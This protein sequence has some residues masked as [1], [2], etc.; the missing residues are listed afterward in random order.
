MISLQRYRDLF[1]LPE[2][3]PV[4]TASIVA[5]MPIGIAGLAILLFVQTR[6]SSFAVAGLV[7]GFYVLGLAA[8]AP[9]LGRLIDR[10]GPRRV[11]SVCAML[12][13][14]ALMVLT[15]LV[16]ARVHPTWLAVMALI[17]G[18]SLPPVSACVRALY[19]RV[20]SEP[21]LLQ[22]VYSVDSAAVEL[23]FT[24][25]PALV[26]ACVAV[27]HP[28]AAVG[29]AALFA[30]VGTGVF[31]RVPTVRRWE[32]SPS[33]RKR[34][35]LGALRQP[36]LLAVFGATVLY[37]IAFGLYEVGVTAHTASKG[38]PA[39][40]GIA[41]ALT[42]VGSG[43]GAIVY[44]ATHWETPLARQFTLALSAMAC[45]ILLLVPIDGL[46][47]YAAVAT[48]TGIPMSSVIAT[49]SQLVSRIASRERLAE[50]FTWAATCLLVGV[51]AG[52]AI[53]GAMAEVLPAYWLIAAA[54]ASTALA[55][56][57]SAVALRSN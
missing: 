48:L 3:R 56:L 22:T 53:G 32:L 50:S 4:V 54:A 20:V 57:W 8:I 43:A 23:V 44:G 34:S 2:V 38:S 28:E 42:S 31:V 13:P 55:A 45:G 29:L 12:Y 17:A 6:S 18:A 7:S 10:I 36:K 14:A 41:L 19:P 51:S 47:L 1:L 27:G 5:R 24:C 40:A 30:A 46:V 25:G 15:L 26:A 33:G 49:Q 16:L 21:A 35:W 39:A 37:A 9:L 52:T 11:L